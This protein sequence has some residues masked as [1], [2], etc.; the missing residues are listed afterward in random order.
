MLNPN[1]FDY[2]LTTLAMRTVTALSLL[3]SVF[4]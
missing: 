3:I 4:C 2:L 1:P